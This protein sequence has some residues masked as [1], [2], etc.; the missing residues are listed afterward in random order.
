[1]TS[2]SNIASSLTSMAEAQP[3][4]DAIIIATGKGD[5]K[6]VSY[7]ELENT[8]KLLALGLL[9]HGVSKGARVVVM[10]K[11]GEEFFSLVFALFKIGAVV[12]AVDP[13][14]GMKNLGTCLAEAEPEV[15]I[16]IPT[17]HLAR[18]LFR[19]AR[20]SL[21]M[22]IIVG[23]RFISGKPSLETIINLSLIHI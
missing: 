8:S 4:N 16:G 11:P 12:V 10:V 14:M 21:K 2:N 19:W 1:M 17:A 20:A 15:F 5:Y 9:D 23:S 13:G 7:R 22:H 18:S 6:T 3:D